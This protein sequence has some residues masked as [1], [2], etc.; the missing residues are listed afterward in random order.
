MKKRVVF[1]SRA[2][3]NGN[4]KQLSKVFKY[5]SKE[6]LEWTVKVRRAARSGMADLSIK[7]VSTAKQVRG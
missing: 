6:Y 4:G 1:S 3:F 5:R 7:D 2:V